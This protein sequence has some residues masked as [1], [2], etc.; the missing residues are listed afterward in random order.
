MLC[1]WFPILGARALGIGQRDWQPPRFPAVAR[2]A[3]SL[4]P[5]SEHPGE[6]LSDR[7]LNNIRDAFRSQGFKLDGG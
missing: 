5:G 3:R 6:P 7:I 1:H 4:R 2:R